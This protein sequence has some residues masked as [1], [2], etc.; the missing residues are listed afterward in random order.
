MRSIIIGIVGFVF[1]ALIYSC[2]GK[3]APQYRIK[4][5]Q[6]N[7]ASVN[8]LTSSS[9]KSGINNIEPGQTTAY[10]TTT[11]GNVTV[12]DILKNESVSFL[13]EKG[14]HYTIIMSSNKPPSLNVDQ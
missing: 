4:N 13:A 8:I 3:A 7:N 11:E 5:E 9:E 14:I 2:S 12:T 10:Q 1:L 6:Q